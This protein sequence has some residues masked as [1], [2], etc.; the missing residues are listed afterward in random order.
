MNHRYARAIARTINEIPLAASINPITR[1][2]VSREKRENTFDA[3]QS[4]A[5]DAG[6]TARAHSHGVADCNGPATTKASTRSEML[7]MMHAPR[8]DRY[9][10]LLSGRL[11]R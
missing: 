3:T 11:D 6:S 5:R 10:S 2:K 1:I 7:N 9:C 8:V 4:P